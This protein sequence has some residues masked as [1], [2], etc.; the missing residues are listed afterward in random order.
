MSNIWNSQ[1]LLSELEIK[2]D[3]LK[4]DGRRLTFDCLN[5]KCNGDRAYCS[6]GKRLGQPK[7]SSLAL[8]TI[9]RGVSCS[10]CK[11]C[12]DFITDEQGD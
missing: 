12:E 7:D 4:L 6:I 10:V 5:L 9:L 11:D 2:R 1:A 3:D 8:I